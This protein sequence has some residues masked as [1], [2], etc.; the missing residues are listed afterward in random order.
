MNPSSYVT[1]EGVPFLLG[2]DVREFIIDSSDCNR[3]RP[4]VSDG[5]LRKSRLTGGD[6]VVVRVGYPGVAA[7]TF[8]R[9]GRGQLCL[10]DDSQETSE[11]LFSVA[12]VPLQ[13]S[14]RARS[15]RDRSV[16]SGSKTVQHQSRSR[17]RFPFPSL[18]EQRAIADY[19]DRETAKLNLM[20]KKVEAAIERLQEYRTALITAAVTGK[21]D[22]RQRESRIAQA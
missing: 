7:V 9:P 18:A 14:G 8:P 5:P 19:L 21:I 22:V 16:R 13:L 6:L 10:D 2:G 1:D 12:R 4:E 15:N 3:C 20:V 11:I 17:L